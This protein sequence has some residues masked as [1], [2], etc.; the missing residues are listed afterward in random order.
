M[1]LTF[2]DP[3]EQIVKKI[4]DV[5]AEDHEHDVIKTVRG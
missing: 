5:L 1:I 2:S 3:K 4:M